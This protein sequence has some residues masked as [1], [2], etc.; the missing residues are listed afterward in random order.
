MEHTFV[1]KKW[2]YAKHI[3]YTASST[4]VFRARCIATEVIR[5]LLAIRCRGNEFTKSL[6]SNGSACHN[7]MTFIPSEGVHSCYILKLVGHKMISFTLCRLHIHF[8]SPPVRSR[9]RYAIWRR[10]LN[11]NLSGIVL[12]FRTNCS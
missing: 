11:M 5:M 10:K 4:L 7:I 3:E 12:L 9:S 8:Q 1:A 2:I 6:P